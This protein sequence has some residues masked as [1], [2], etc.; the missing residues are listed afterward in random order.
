MNKWLLN[1]PLHEKLYG[2]AENQRETS[3]FVREIDVNACSNDE[4][5]DAFQ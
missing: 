4:E 1:P 5:K 2:H 3:A